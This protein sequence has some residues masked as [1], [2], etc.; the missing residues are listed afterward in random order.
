MGSAAL[1]K[2]LFHPKL[3]QNTKTHEDQR[4]LKHA[5]NRHSKAMRNAKRDFL[6]N[7]YE[8]NLGKWK[9]LKDVTGDNK[10]GLTKVTVEGEEVTSPAQ[11]ADLYSEAN[12][13]KLQT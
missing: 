7:K 5:Q 13:K 1:R 10:T 8:T 9:Q 4:Q 12:L 2:S 3:A 6:R 11:L